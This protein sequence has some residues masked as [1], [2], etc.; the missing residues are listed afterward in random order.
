M[1]KSRHLKSAAAQNG[2]DK[3][4]ASALAA[5]MTA[6]KFPMADH[7]WN[8]RIKFDV[9]L[10]LDEIWIDSQTLDYLNSY[11]ENI[12][13]SQGFPISTVPVQ[14]VAVAQAET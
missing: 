9:S 12:F 4:K 6:Y 11:R 14:P 5:T 2:R 1:E 10:G 8:Y 3:N 7:R 13:V